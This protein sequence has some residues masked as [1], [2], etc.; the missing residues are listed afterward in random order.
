MKNR[1]WSII[2]Y[3]IT[4]TLRRRSY[5][6]LT[7]IVPVVAII[8]V[9]AITLL[10]GKDS[11]EA[12]TGNTNLPTQPVGY[13]DQSSLLGQPESFAGIFV[14]YPDETAARA[15]IQSGEISAYY[16]VPAD[17]LATGQV[18][19]YAEQISLIVND[20]GLFQSFLESALL[21]QE[22][23]VVAARIQSPVI[24]VENIV[25][26]DGTETATQQNGGMDLFWLV[27]LFGMLMML[28]TFLTAGQL[29]QSVIKEKENRVMEIVLSSLRPL[30][31]M[32]GKITG[33]GVMGLLQMI[34]WLV[35]IFLIVQLA[36]V[37]IPILSFLGAAELPASLLAAALLYFILGFAL[38]GAFAAAVGAISANMREGPQYAVLYSVPAALA[39]IF[40][41]SIAQAPNT[42]LA[43]ILSLFPMTAPIAMIE[44]MVITAVP[45][46]QVGLSLGLLA[47]SVVLGLWLSARLFQVNSL[48]SGQVPDR[49][50]LV[51]ILVSG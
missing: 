15:A 10:Q 46:W 8:L 7:F 11:A 31:L 20:M 49:K 47:L 18:T 37:Q 1:V 3:E 13:V 50:E 2:H 36:D 9:G 17:Y 51:R 25:G 29:T 30:Q 39:I 38:F 44:R 45:I 32:V 48:L 12:D 26:S 28:T 33:Q 22:E 41:P 14:A 23:P 27:Y 35:A 42:T 19:R 16:L 6:A 5:L 4:E 40:L 21:A 43:L 24:L 34:T